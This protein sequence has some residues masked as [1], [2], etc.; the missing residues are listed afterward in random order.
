[1]TETDTKS[2]QGQRPCPWC[3]G[4]GQVKFPD[5]HPPTVKG[6]VITCPKCNGTK[7]APLSTK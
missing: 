6:N 4:T 7:M 3:K 2:Q 1:M 5:P